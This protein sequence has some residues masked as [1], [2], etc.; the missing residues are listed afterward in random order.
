MLFVRGAFQKQLSIVLSFKFL[1]PK[2]D[3][4][5][6]YCVY[7]FIDPRARLKRKSNAKVLSS[8]YVLRTAFSYEFCS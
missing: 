4:S 1:L 2:V 6:T 3:K 7:I 5:A 8:C